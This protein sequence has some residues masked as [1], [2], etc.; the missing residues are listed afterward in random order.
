M[1]NL[2]SFR[3]KLNMTQADVAKALNLPGIDTPMISRFE[4]EVCFPNFQTK[5]LFAN[6]FS[7]EIDE[8]YPEDAKSATDAKLDEIL[9]KLDLILEKDK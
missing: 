2:T 3:K 4:K 6:L 9:N 7:C 1:N 5:T 8:L